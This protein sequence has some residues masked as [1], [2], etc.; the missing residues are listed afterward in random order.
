MNKATF[1]GKHIRRPGDTA[2]DE[3]QPV[4]FVGDIERRYAAQPNN[5][6]AIKTGR[7]TTKRSKEAKRTAE[8]TGWLG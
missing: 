5:I 6:N 1:H 7:Y 2:L 3:H 8:Y 4:F